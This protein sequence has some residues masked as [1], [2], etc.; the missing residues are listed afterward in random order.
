MTPILVAFG[1]AAVLSAVVGVS[2]RGT[3]IFPKGRVLWRAYGSAEDT[4]THYWWVPVMTAFFSAVAGAWVAAQSHASVTVPSR[5]VPPMVLPVHGAGP[6]WPKVF[7][8]SLAV[9]VGLYLLLGLALFLGHLWRYRRA[10]H[11]DPVWG[12]DDTFAQN[13]A[14]FRLRRRENTA[15]FDG[16]A[17]GIMQVMIRLPD[18]TSVVI[19]DADQAHLRNL[20]STVEATYEAEPPPTGDY[21]VRWYG[22]EAPVHRGRR[23]RYYEIARQ[24]AHYDGPQPA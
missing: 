22:S 17:F 3:A 1:A 11:T 19:E 8:G 23:H 21:E 12:T 9:G 16:G 24:F 7:L 5:S 4:L 20:G 15:P 13:I 18:G 6:S 10:H 14:I 2:V